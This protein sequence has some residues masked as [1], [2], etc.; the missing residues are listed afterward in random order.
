MSWISSSKNQMTQSGSDGR[1]AETVA[2]RDQLTLMNRLKMY[3]QSDAT[4][5]NASRNILLNKLEK[6]NK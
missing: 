3:S 1:G 5:S 6:Y 4:V 2:A